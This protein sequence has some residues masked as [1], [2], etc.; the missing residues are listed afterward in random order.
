MPAPLFFFFLEDEKEN[1]CRLAAGD[2]SAEICPC[3]KFV[4]RKKGARERGCLC[5]CCLCQSKC[6]PA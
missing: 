5:A 6:M 4:N 2:S 3:G 1:L